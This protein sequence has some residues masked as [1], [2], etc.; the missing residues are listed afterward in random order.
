L[1]PPERDQ[2]EFTQKMEG[3]DTKNDIHQKMDDKEQLL[4]EDAKT[5]KS[6]GVRSS[7]ANNSKN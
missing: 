6:Y 3:E 2:N 5:N 7:D 4:K 1:V